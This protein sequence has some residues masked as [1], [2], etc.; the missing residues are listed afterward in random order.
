M[1]QI[2]ILKMFLEILLAP[3]IVH[4]KENQIAR[5]GSQ[6]S[7][8]FMVQFIISNIQNSGLECL[9]NCLPFTRLSSLD[10]IIFKLFCLFLC[11]L[12]L[13]FTL[14]EAKHQL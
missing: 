2:L 7:F 4:S 14:C 6:D 11:F 1:H 9:N 5:K 10:S 12:K 13:R 3:N 8:H